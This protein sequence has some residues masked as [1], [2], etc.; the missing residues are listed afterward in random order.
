[1]IADSCQALKKKIQRHT[2][3]KRK[4]INQI[5]PVFLS[6]KCS[7][8]MV[9]FKLMPQC[10]ICSTFNSY[11]L[12]KQFFMLPSHFFMHLLYLLI[13]ICYNK[14]TFSFQLCQEI[15]IQKKVNC[16]S[17]MKKFP[18]Y[19]DCNE[20]VELLLVKHVSNG[21]WVIFLHFQFFIC[22]FQSSS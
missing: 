8:I 9:N 13:Q 5:K 6:L 18:L 21:A 7:I 20:L 2:K 4:V 22:L 1:M 17:C 12:F 10:K 11:K 14:F 16:Y 19:Y 3:Y 15:V